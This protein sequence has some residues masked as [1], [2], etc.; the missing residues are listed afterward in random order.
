MKQS[1]HTKCALTASILSMIVCCAMLIGS[2]FAWFTDSVTSA[3]NK[4]VAGK[5]DVALEWANGTEALETAAW[6]DASTAAIFDYDLWEPGYAEV[7]HVRISNK[8]NLALKYEIRIVANGEAGKLADVIDVYYI[9]GG[10]QIGSRNQ[11]DE[12]NKIGTLADILKKPYAGKGH[13]TGMKDNV[14]SSD[15]AT[16][17]LKM[18]E[19]AGNEYQ[20]MSIGT[21]FS[22]QLVATQYTEENDN[23]DN[24]YDKDAGFP[25]NASTGA[26][27]NHA[28]ANSSN[29]EITLISGS[30][31]TDEIAIPN[32]KTVKLT[33]DEGSS[34][35]P[36]G[37]YGVRVKKGGELTLSGMGTISGNGYQIPV[38]NSGILTINDNI[39]ISLTNPGLTEGVLSNAGTGTLYIS[40]GTYTAEG[41]SGVG[42]KNAGGHAYISGG[43]FKGG[44]YAFFTSGNGVTEISD[45]TFEGVIHSTNGTDQSSTTTIRGGNF[46]NGSL[47]TGGQ[48]KI[49]VTGGT[50]TGYALSNVQQYLADGYIA[51]E[52]DGVITVTASK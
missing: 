2:T 3:G 17:A 33:L 22:I 19:S 42:V 44:L 15:I 48:S 47:S 25:V 21:D 18:Q 16:I 41:R 34:V 36:N 26:E 23:F 29:A 7:R 6:K 43:N 13:I 50:F 28:I 14:V 30:N 27:I 9:Q 8:G 12:S 40:D 32:G 24:Q 31:I 49:V 52:H 5:L 51:A 20:G 10:R 39:K 4:I 37:T 45:G 11:L 38:S 35:H 1:K 46:K